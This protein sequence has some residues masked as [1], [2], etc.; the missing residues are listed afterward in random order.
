MSTN[1]FDIFNNDTLDAPGPA[2]KPMPS[3]AKAQAGE[4]F[5]ETC[6]KCRGSGSFISY[7]G[8]NL[9]PCFACK[10]KGKNVYATSPEERAKSRDRAAVKRVEKAH[11][12]VEDTRSWYATYPAEIAWLQQA[13]KR[14]SARAG[15]FTFPADL[16]DK[17]NQYGSLTDAQLASVRKLMARD[18][19]RQVARAATA[20]AIDATKIEK[21]FAVA[22][23]KANRPGQM[24][25]FTKPLKLTSPDPDKI[26]LSFRPGSP[27]SQWADM[28]FVK[29]H[30]DRKLGHIKGGKFFRKFDCSPA[31]E[32][33]VIAC[34]A[35]P[36][37]AVVAFAKAWSACGVCGQR[38]LNDVSIARGIGPICAEKFGWTT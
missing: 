37:T 35:D 28:L 33:A 32:A 36:E 22:R 6:P 10:G 34:A 15:S 16:L 27:G 26:T 25:T 30:D 1:P 4:E 2:G 9:G 18:T 7:G 14:N 29:S 19:E 20:P 8:R 11:Q 31:E 38:L 17:L 24:G 23:E 12:I 3:I 5:V 13:A 21:A